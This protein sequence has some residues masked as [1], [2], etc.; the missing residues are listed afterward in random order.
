MEEMMLKLDEFSHNHH[1]SRVKMLANFF[2]NGIWVAGF[3]SGSLN[4]VL[5]LAKPDIIPEKGY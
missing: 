3:R 5:P 4:E 1:P 2:L